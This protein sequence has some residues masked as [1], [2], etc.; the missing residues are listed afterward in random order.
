M[1]WQGTLKDMNNTAYIQRTFKN[2]VPK[3]MKWN[4]PYK[5]FFFLDTGDFEC[6]ENII[7]TS[8]YLLRLLSFKHIK[9]HKFMI[10]L[11]FTNLLSAEPLSANIFT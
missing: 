2:N 5:N 4:V 1:S 10:F 3:M 11:I 8:V 7:H 9:M 6:S